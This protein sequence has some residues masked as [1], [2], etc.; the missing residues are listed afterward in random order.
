[1]SFFGPKKVTHLVTQWVITL[2]RLQLYLSELKKAYGSVKSQMR[3][4]VSPRPGTVMAYTACQAAGAESYA[5]L[6]L[7]VALEGV[8]AFIRKCRASWANPAAGR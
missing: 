5:K 1:M 3:V 7:T 4:R 2:G 8:T 6:V